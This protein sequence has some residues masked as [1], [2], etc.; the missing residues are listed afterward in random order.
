MQKRAVFYVDE[1]MQE[2]IKALKQSE[3]YDKSYSDLYRHLISEGLKA[4]K[5]G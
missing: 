5:K 2:D 3:F 1:E 4:K